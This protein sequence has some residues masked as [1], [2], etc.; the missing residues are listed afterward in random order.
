VIVVTA[1]AWVLTSLAASRIRTDLNPRRDPSKQLSAEIAR[2]ARD[3]GAGVRRLLHT[4]RALVPIASVTWNQLLNGL[5]FVIS[6]VVFRERFHSGAG[7][8]SSLVIAGG[9]GLLVG[10][11]TVGVL[12]GRFARRTMMASSFVISGV[13]LAS[14]SPAINRYDILVVSFL[15]GLAFAWLK[16]PADT[17]TQEATPDR[18][19]G[20]VF[21]IYDIAQNM[22]GVISALIAIGLVR[23]VSVSWLVAGVG[24][25]FLLW[26]P[27][28]HRWMGRSATIEVRSYAG[29]RA[30]ETPRSVVLGGVESEVEVERSWR[31]ER[32]GTR[33]LCFRL[34]LPDGQRI[35]VSR[36]EDGG[37]WHLDREL[38]G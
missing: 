1:A 6:L 7:S 38:A 35:E 5:M 19:R 31:E 17:T 3:L 29:S 8:Y 11:S 23:V 32:A 21:A 12:E 15:L 16:V 25:L 13:A 22:S 20:R 27:L 33:L 9:A 30:D 14:V 2:V 10:L 4:P 36:A 28:I 34:A 24:V 37:P 26:T 18:Y